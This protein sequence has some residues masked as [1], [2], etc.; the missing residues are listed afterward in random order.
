MSLLLSQVL[1][2]F[3]IG[4]IYALIALGFCLISGVANVI[5]FA[6]GSLFMLG[7][8]IA[9]TG[10]SIGLPLAV[11][12]AIAIAAAALLGLLLERVALR[13]LVGAPYIAPFLSTLA[14]SVMADQ[15]AEL[16]W[17]PDSQPFPSLWA[18]H[19][20]FVGSAYITGT[21]VAIF[22][23]GLAATVVL[24]LYL[25]RTWV[26]RALRATAQDPDAAAQLGVRTGAVR[27]IAFGLAGA[28][29]ALGGILTALYYQSVFPQMGVPFGLKGFAAAVIGGLSSIPGAAL[30]GLALGIIEALASGYV[31][32]EYRD[33]I[34]FT[35]MLV[36]LMV[37]PRGI[38]GKR[39]LDALGGQSGAAGAI[40]T[41]SL[42]ASSA[43]QRGRHRILALSP[44]GFLILGA[45]LA[46][47]P[48]IVSSPY[49]L[50]AFTYGLIFALLAAS[51]SLFSGTAGLLSLGH[52]AFFGVGA[53]SVALLAA[54]SGPPLEVTLAT[55]AAVTALAAMLVTVPLQRLSSDTIALGTLAVGQIGFLVFQNW[56]SLTRGP[57]GISD[58][59]HPQSYLLGHLAITS[60][61]GR[62]WLVLC[63]VTM[64][65]VTAERLVS[66][67]IGRAWR[68]IREDRLAA[69]AAGLPVRRYVMLAAAVSG[70]LAGLAGGLFAYVQTLVSPESFNVQTSILILTMGVLGGL[71]NLTGA[72]VAGF[73]LAIVP[74]LLR[75]FAD[76]RMIAYGA[77]LLLT[78]RLRPQ[79][80]LGAR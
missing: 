55:A 29:G 64:A 9:F 67:D 76:Y 33:A 26:G 30:G 69:L 34:A 17:S 68:A 74:E 50:Q 19:T 8:F 13:P 63:L 78:L 72:A 60:V 54:P 2:G 27:Q 23:V 56:V 14:I 3:A 25:D 53:Y 4:Q 32:D 21:D 70:A 73:A 15:A 20:F 48:L 66:T 43:S 36:V 11:A 58:I 18:D 12:A 57:M 1:N 52:A 75:G 44:R 61:R 6:Q 38:L 37:Y 45:V 49:V 59:P 5:N 71:G 39:T 62:A 31:G 22:G 7:A 65:F 24:T 16:V 80:A 35:V 79:G 46:L 77:L 42:L 41:T 28:L 47:A 10:V 51:V 40:P